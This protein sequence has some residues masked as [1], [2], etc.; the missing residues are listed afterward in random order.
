MGAKHV[1]LV[2]D[3]FQLGPVVT[4]KRA[5]RAGLS[6]SLFERL[7]D[8][9][10]SPIR[11]KIQYRMHPCL[12]EFPSNMFYEGTLQNGVSSHERTLSDIQFPWPV[13]SKPMMF[14]SQTGQEE[15]ALAARH[16]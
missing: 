14:W 12:S 6:Q 7:I 16:S 8:L 4:C 13:P 11:L 15:M 2:G 10:I 3:H 1:V 9:G 5:Y